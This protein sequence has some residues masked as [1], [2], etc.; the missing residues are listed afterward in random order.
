[1]FFFFEGG[2]ESDL[3][4]REINVRMLVIKKRRGVVGLGGEKVERLHIWTKCIA[5]SRL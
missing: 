4:G 5:N 1:M 3:K 2:G